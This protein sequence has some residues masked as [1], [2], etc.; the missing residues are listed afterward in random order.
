MFCIVRHKGPS[1]RR[2]SGNHCIVGQIPG[3]R[4]GRPNG[5]NMQR[6]IRQCLSTLGYSRVTGRTSGGS[7]YDGVDARDAGIMILT[8]AG[9]HHQI[10]AQFGG[11]NSQHRFRCQLAGGL[12]DQVGGFKVSLSIGVE[13]DGKL[14]YSFRFQTGQVRN[15]RLSLVIIGKVC[16]RACNG[17][18]LHAVEAH[19]RLCQSSL[20]VDYHRNI[21]FQGRLGDG[22][23]HE[24]VIFIGQAHR[25]MP[26]LLA[27]HIHGKDAVA[28]I[29]HA[30]HG[31]VKPHIHTG[32][33]DHLGASLYHRNRT[34]RYG[35][36]IE[37]CIVEVIGGH[38]IISFGNNAAGVFRGPAC[39]VRPLAKSDQQ[40]LHR[41]GI[42]GKEHLAVP[43]QVRRC[44]PGLGKLQSTV[45]L[46][47]EVF[48]RRKG[49]RSGNHPVHKR[50]CIR[51]GVCTRQYAGI[52]FGSS[53][54]VCYRDTGIGNLADGLIAAGLQIRIAAENRLFYDVEV[55][56]QRACSGI[57]ACPGNCAHVQRIL[58]RES[59]QFAHRVHLTKQAAGI[60]TRDIYGVDKTIDIRRVT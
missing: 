29:G 16:G 6:S 9:D 38:T 1:I 26:A 51:I 46:Q 17:I 18:D 10:G 35:G 23:G 40:R 4:T 34:A 47:P 37:G 41:D 50:H 13:V 48:R 53:L 49:Q 3:N 12:I 39:N 36:G 20:R 31:P 27:G 22:I 30:F 5:A 54:A 56:H 8:C 7:L 19:L 60:W 15:R 55:T 57:S 42:A 25:N 59:L 21:D 58:Y 32:V 52:Q 43:E 11:R 28:L 44:C 14:G 2:S 33:Q 24:A 45:I